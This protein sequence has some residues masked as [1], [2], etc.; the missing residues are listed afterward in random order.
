MKVS[1]EWDEGNDVK[2]YTKHG[3]SR[4]E[5]ESLFHDPGRLDFADPLHS[6]VEN[7]FVTVGRSSRPRILLVAWTLR[8]RRVRVI[9]ARPASRKERRVYEERSK[10]RGA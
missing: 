5:A 7:R 10:T 6:G 3:V 8:G 1:F 4:E 9:S 2:S